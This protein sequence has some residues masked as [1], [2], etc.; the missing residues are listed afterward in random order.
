MKIILAPDSFKENL[1]SLEV[2]GEIEKGIR[3][4]LPGARCIKVPMADGG[5]GTVQSMVD[6]TG[7][8]VVRCR[9]KAPL[10]NVVTARY[11][12]L[13]GGRTAVIEMAEASGLHL[14]PPRR[15]NPLLTSTFGTGQLLLDALNRG[16]RTIIIGIGG[17]ATNDGGAGMAQALGA[18]FL[19]AAGRPLRGPACG[20][21]LDR[22]RA[23]DVSGMDPR[24][25]RVKILVA[26]DVTNP[27][28]GPRGASHV[29]GRQ[30]GATP[31]MAAK[32]D[33]NLR[34][35]AR[36]IK[37][38]LGVDVAR[39]PGAGA[40]G[41][42]GAGLMAFTRAQL[43]RG[44]EL[45]VKATRLESRMRGADLAITGEGRVDFQTAFGKTPAGV[46]AAARRHGVPVV[47]IGGGLA[48]DARGVFAHGID[49]LESATPDAMP[50]P[51][52]I[53]KS[54][55]YLQDAGERVARLILIG[56]NMRRRRG[57]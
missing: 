28:Y 48:D 52:A 31:A 1:T 8:R 17:S 11:G 5:E 29:Y 34:H 50:L 12:L 2:A 27:L 14:V 43:K 32:L 16:V 41:G 24:L 38:D 21:M 23:L 37:R 13:G 3:R 22:I 45:V 57:R 30:K 15:R 56:R 51:V 9:V 42:L 46:A 6:A 18:R 55:Q 10:G 36:I 26:C 33:R 4:V 54:R 35:F 7:G 53:R 20:G 49:G 47:A 25:R 19:D 39:R 44:V 40:A